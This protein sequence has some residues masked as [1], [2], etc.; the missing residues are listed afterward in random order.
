MKLDW[1]PLLDKQEW[2]DRPAREAKDVADKHESTKLDKKL[3]NRSFDNRKFIV[4]VHAVIGGLIILG[5]LLAIAW[6]IISAF[7]FAFM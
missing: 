3:K 4:G 1:D 2:D 6:V 7:K 5:V